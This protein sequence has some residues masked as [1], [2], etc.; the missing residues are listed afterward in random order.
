MNYN[1]CTDQQLIVSQQYYFIIHVI[2]I[3]CDSPIMLPKP[4]F[5]L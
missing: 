3:Q 5:L 4:P 2:Y 1:I